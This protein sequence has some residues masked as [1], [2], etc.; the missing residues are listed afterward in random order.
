M[1]KAIDSPM[2]FFAKKSNGRL[3]RHMPTFLAYAFLFKD[4]SDYLKY[5]SNFLRRML[6][7]LVICTTFQINAQ[8]HPFNTVALD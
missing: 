8:L 4:T 3:S 7:F 6:N 1:E 2:A 5:M